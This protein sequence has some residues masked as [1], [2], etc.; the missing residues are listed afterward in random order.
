MFKYDDAGAAA[1]V[2]HVYVIVLLFLNQGI[3]T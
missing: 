1:F 2:G 3:L